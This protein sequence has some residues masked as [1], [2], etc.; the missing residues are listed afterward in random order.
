MCKSKAHL[1]RVVFGIL[2][3]KAKG[4]NGTLMQD[5]VCR[6][7]PF[8]FF[9][10]NQARSCWMKLLTVLPS[11]ILRS[12]PRLVRAAL[13]PHNPH[14]PEVSDD[15]IFVL[16]VGHHFF[17]RHPWSRHDAHY[18]LCPGCAG[19]HH[20]RL[21]ADA[22]MRR[23]YCGLEPRDIWRRMVRWELL[24]LVPLSGVEAAC[25][26]ERCRFVLRCPS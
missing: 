22:S 21:R 10:P 11:C 5:Q 3:V 6:R 14:K 20:R 4:I 2:G 26:Q 25:H 15:L 1:M 16:G 18:S 9:K 24:R 12:S 7:S 17:C 8:L 19:Y 13:C 23:S